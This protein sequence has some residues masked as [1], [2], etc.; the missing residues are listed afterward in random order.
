MEL[1]PVISLT[2]NL[3]SFQ[4][5]KEN[6]SLGTGTPMFTPIIPADAFS[7]KCLARL[8]LWVKMEAAFP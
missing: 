5:P 1:L 2:P 7:M 3:L 4:P 8:P 6:G